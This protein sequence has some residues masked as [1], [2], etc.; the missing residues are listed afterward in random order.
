LKKRE[1]EE[2][3]AAILDKAHNEEKKDDVGNRV[4]N[5]NRAASSSL[6]RKSKINFEAYQAYYNTND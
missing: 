4:A 6:Q 5:V 3:A 1:V 2:E